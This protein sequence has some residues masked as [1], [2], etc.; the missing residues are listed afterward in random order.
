MNHLFSITLI[1]TSSINFSLI[2]SYNTEDS[3]T[4]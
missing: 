3:V 1:K 4:P 2:L